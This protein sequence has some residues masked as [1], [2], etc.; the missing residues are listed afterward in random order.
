MNERREGFRCN[1]D[2]DVTISGVSGRICNL[3]MGGMMCFL[4]SSV[5]SMKTLDISFKI[6][7]YE[8]NIKGTVL[9]C[10]EITKDNFSVGV[11]FNTPTMS[12][13]DRNKLSIYLDELRRNV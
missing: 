12:D 1:A 11:Y 7:D 13:V 4:D 6:K 9:R 8:I 5:P 2:T 10:E 3:S